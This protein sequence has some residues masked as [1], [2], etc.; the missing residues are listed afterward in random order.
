[1]F[2]LC[3]NRIEILFVSITSFHISAIIFIGIEWFKMSFL[4]LYVFRIRRCGRKINVA[5]LT[6]QSSRKHVAHLFSFPRFQLELNMNSHGGN[7]SSRSSHY[8]QTSPLL[9]LHVI[10][11]ATLK[12][13]HRVVLLY[14]TNVDLSS[15]FLF[16]LQ[17]EITVAFVRRDIVVFILWSLFGM[18]TISIWA[19]EV[20]VLVT[21]YLFHF[22]CVLCNSFHIWIVKILF[23][24]FL[25]ISHLTTCTTNL[26]NLNVCEPVHRVHLKLT[27]F[28]LPPLKSFLSL[29]ETSWNVIIPSNVHRS[30][31]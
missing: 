9:L 22:L 3:H 2:L 4:N 25:H 31:Y 27:D 10:D 14:T 11:S 21:R 24:F 13:I 30:R 17:S 23:A 16:I 1:M 8:P 18:Q 12:R 7:G 20:L 15:H 5:T 26:D 19:L 29:S 6:R 28:S